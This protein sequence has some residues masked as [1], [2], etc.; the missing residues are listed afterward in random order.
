MSKI[1][2]RPDFES[3]MLPKIQKDKTIN[4]DRLFTINE[5]FDM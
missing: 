4:L 2:K 5:H 3:H 1:M